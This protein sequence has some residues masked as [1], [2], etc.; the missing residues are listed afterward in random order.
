MAEKQELQKIK[1]YFTQLRD[2]NEQITEDIINDQLN[3]LNLSNDDFKNLKKF[4]DSLELTDVE[5]DS[6][7]NWFDTLELEEE[8]P[9]MVDD[10]DDDIDDIDVDDDGLITGLF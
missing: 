3:G 7:M 5:V 6:I 1:E 8:T 4:F 10:I 2:S 9:E